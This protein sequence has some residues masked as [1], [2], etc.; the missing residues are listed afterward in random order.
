MYI[1]VSQSLSILILSQTCLKCTLVCTFR[2]FACHDNLDLNLGYTMSGKDG[3]TGTKFNH[4]PE[5]IENPDK[6]T[7]Y[8]WQYFH[9]IGHQEKI[10]SVPWELE[11]KVGTWKEPIKNCSSAGIVLACQAGDI[12]FLV[13]AH[14]EK[15][16]SSSKKEGS[17]LWKMPVLTPF[18]LVLCYA[19]KFWA[20]FNSRTG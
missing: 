13:P 2:T 5:T 6:M 11:N 7:K 12:R 10:R 8:I 17:L 18:Q 20:V 9:F 16:C 19:L 1:C 14:V 15:K 4:M 3:I